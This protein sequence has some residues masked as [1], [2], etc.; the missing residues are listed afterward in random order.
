[1]NDTCA[2]VYGSVLRTGVV[3]VGAPVYLLQGD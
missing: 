1:M 2:G 3:A